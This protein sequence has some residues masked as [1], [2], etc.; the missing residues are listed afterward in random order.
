MYMYPAL[1]IRNNHENFDIVP[2]TISNNT[3]GLM[4]GVVS[5]QCVQTQIL[6]H[7]TPQSFEL[8]LRI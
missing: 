2:C 4:V 8:L 5:P 7:G 1:R 3:C 6:N